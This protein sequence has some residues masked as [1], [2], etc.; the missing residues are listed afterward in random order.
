MTESIEGLSFE[1][2][3]KVHYIQVLDAQVVAK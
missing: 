1:K 2:T 3:D